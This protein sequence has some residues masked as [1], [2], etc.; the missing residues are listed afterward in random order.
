MCGLASPLDGILWH[1]ELRPVAGASC[2][3]SVENAC[4]SFCP[5]LG[6]GNGGAASASA[7]FI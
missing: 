6:S 4:L 5:G 1:T 7:D 2:Q 3:V